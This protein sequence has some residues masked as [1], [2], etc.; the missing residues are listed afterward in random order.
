MKYVKSVLALGAFF[1][2]AA[3]LSACGSS[4]VSGGSVAEMAGNQISSQAFKH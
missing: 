4:S 3:G 1:V 2:L